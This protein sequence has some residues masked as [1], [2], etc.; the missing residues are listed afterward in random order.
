M[1]DHT[2]ISLG[3]SAV[4]L[5]VLVLALRNQWRR[6]RAVRRRLRALEKEEQRM[7]SFLHDLGL[8]IENEPSPLMLSRIIVDGIVQVVEAR[9]GAG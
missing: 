4:V 8:A 3:V 7:F 2:T 9:G 1:Q 5:I 6:S